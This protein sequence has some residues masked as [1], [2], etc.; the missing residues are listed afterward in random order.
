VDWVGLGGFKSQASQ[1]SYFFPISSNPWVT[2]LTEQGLTGVFIWTY[3][4][5]RF[6]NPTKFELEIEP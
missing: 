2:G 5:S 3:N 4:L 1:T 6:Y